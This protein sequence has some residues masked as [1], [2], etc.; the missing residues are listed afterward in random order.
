MTV[1]HNREY[2]LERNAPRIMTDDQTGHIFVR[3]QIMFEPFDRSA[4]QL[5]K[6]D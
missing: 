4:I 2:D 5:T 6:I 1:R 3:N